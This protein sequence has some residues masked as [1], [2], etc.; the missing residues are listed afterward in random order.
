MNKRWITLFVLT[1]LLLSFTAACEKKQSKKTPEA[2]QNAPAISQD[3]GVTPT[4]PVAQ[5]RIT[6]QEAE[7]IALN[8]A[9]LTREQV[10]RLY[11]NADYDDGVPEY[12]VQ[13]EYERLEY[14]YEIHAE[15]GKILSF[16]KDH[17]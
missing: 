16:D 6:A 13:F 12:E 10:Q 2:K 17:D 15:N 5:D 11:S 7:D 3:T 14:E 1:A 8:H 9:G 4:K